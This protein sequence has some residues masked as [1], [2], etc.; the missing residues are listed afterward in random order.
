MLYGGWGK[1][2]RKTPTARQ[3]KLKC[4]P[5]TAVV[6]FVNLNDNGTTNCKMRAE[7]GIDVLRD[8]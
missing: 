5:C 8:S 4:P 2:A 1:S 3:F 6:I 7:L